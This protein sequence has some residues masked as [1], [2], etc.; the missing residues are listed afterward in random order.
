MNFV[1]VLF[2]ALFCARLFNDSTVHIHS[3][4]ITRYLVSGIW[5][6]SKY[7]LLSRRDCQNIWT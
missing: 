1:S 2:S 3:Y 7:R 5:L 4:Q 6:V